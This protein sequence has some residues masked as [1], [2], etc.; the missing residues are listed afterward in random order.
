[1]KS[2][3]ITAFILFPAFCFAQTQ[4]VSFLKNDGSPVSSKDSA[5]FVRVISEP[6]SG[7]KLY[8]VIDYYVSGKRKAIG[9]STS[10]NRAW[11]QGVKLSFFE[12][13]RRKATETYEGGVL[14]GE[15]DEYFPN[16]KLYA[17]K[18]YLLT[19]SKEEGSTYPKK[20][21]LPIVKETYDSLGVKQVTGGNGTYVLY[22]ENFTAIAEQGLVKDGKRD[23][24]WNGTDEVNKAT[25]KETYNNGVL[26]T[27]TANYNGTTSTYS[28]TRFTQ[29]GFASGDKGFG[30]FLGHGIRYPAEAREK[31]ITGTV[32]LMFTVTSA[33]EVKDISVL[34]SVHPSLDNESVRVL[35]STPKW[36]PATKYGQAVSARYL[37]PINY[38]LASR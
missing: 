33:G 29:P 3:F 20:I 4:N 10:A 7:S 34:T 16:G 25:F 2:L 18:E 13:G 27:G 32:M 15:S 22:N 17:H 30:K 24:E 8:N 9:K 6:D 37:M 28:K 1:M 12:N 26:I 11:F 14:S 38:A 31:N 19:E 21:S 36:I 5:D 35:Q 23:G